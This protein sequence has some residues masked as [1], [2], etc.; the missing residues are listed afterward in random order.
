MSFR[1]Q[2]NSFN[3][4]YDDFIVS[5]I[6]FFPNVHKIRFYRELFTQFKKTDYRLPG[7]LFLSSVGPH[8]IHIFNRNDDYFMSGIEVT[9]T[10]ERAIIEKTIVKE[11]INMTDEQK[12]TV[13][14]Y[15]EKMLFIIM[16]IEDDDDYN[17]QNSAEQQA[18]E[19]LC[20]SFQSDGVMILK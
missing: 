13:W 3:R 8:C 11:W 10:R 17:N 12:D 18:G 15:L 2:Y 1:E 7:R 4:L 14:F 6:S 9:K 20:N 19:I 16:N 5:L